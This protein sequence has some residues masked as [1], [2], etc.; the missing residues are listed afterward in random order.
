MTDRSPSA[1]TRMVPVTLELS[2]CGSGHVS[3]SGDVKKLKISPK[4]RVV[5][6][7][8]FGADIQV[9]DVALLPWTYPW[10]RRILCFVWWKMPPFRWIARAFGKSPYRQV[11]AVARVRPGFKVDGDRRK[12]DNSM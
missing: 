8:G 2:I 4:A 10:P 7:P 12:A 1:W 6:T 3:E 5:A 9:T 11:V